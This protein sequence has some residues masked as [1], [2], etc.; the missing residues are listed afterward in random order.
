MDVTFDPEKDAVNLAKHGVSLTLAWEIDWSMVMAYV[1][2]RKDYKEIREIG[3]CPISGRLY[4]VVFTQR[5]GAMR[6]ISLRKAS[7]RETNNYERQ[8]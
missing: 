2:I 4:C 1:D 5:G 6:V 3:F 7:N 8:T